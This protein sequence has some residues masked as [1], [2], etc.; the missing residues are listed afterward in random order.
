MSLVSSVVQS[1]LLSALVCTVY[2][3]LYTQVLGHEMREFSICVQQ[4]CVF[5]LVHTCTY[6]YNVVL[7]YCHKSNCHHNNY[8]HVHVCIIICLLKPQ[9]LMIKNPTLPASWRQVVRHLV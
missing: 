2:Y 7:F 4:L 3:I 1:T 6:I 8:C 5:S 9:N